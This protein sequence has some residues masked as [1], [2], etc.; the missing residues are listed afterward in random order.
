M[1]YF[2]EVF[3]WLGRFGG[4]GVVHCE[5]ST[6]QTLR[7]RHGREGGVIEADRE[8]GVKRSCNQQAVEI[9]K[10]QIRWMRGVN[11]HS[12]YCPFFV[13]FWVFREQGERVA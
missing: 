12:N 3:L 11:P 1:R 5:N 7:G 4:L 13:E 8:E 9:V 10:R 2:F 6:E